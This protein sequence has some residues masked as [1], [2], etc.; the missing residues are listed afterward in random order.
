M[1]GCVIDNINYGKTAYIHAPFCGTGYTGPI[2]AS[3]VSRLSSFGNK[4]RIKCCNPFIRNG[5]IDQLPIK[6]E[7]VEFLLKLVPVRLLTNRSETSKLQ[8]I[9]PTFDAQNMPKNANNKV[10]AGFI[11]L[12][13]NIIFK[14]TEY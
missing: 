5:L 2:S 8:E 11:Q 13:E 12:F 4:T 10:F 1:K 9:N 14:Y 7:E 3:S 6:G